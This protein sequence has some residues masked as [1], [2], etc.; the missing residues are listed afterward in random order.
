MSEPIPDNYWIVGEG[1]IPDF[2]RSRTQPTLNL[3]IADDVIDED[4][5]TVLK[6]ASQVAGEQVA[7]RLADA[8]V[9]VDVLFAVQMKDIIAV[10]LQKTITFQSVVFEVPVPPAPD[11]DSPVDGE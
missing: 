3:V 10:G 5:V 1:Q 2:G 8:G 11:D 6:A 4:G 7:Q 9:F